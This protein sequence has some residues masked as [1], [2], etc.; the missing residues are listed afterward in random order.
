M[1]K[2]T[3]LGLFV[4]VKKLFLSTSKIIEDYNPLIEYLSLLNEVERKHIMPS[5]RDLELIRELSSRL[6]KIDLQEL[7]EELMKIKEPLL[8]EDIAIR[9]VEKAWGIRL[10]RELAIKEISK[11]LA[12][13]MLEIAERLN[14]IKIK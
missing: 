2:P 11:E 4:M 7:M 3:I 8:K 1:L 12:G 13:W 6:G 10:N 14:I 9:A 5:S